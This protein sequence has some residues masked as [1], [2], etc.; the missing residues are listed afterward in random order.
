MGIKIKQH[1]LDLNKKTYVVTI[2]DNDEVLI[3]KKNI[4]CKT[5]LNANGDVI[6]DAAESL[7]RIKNIVA[8]RRAEE[9]TANV[10][11]DLG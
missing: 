2:E 9:Y 4:G 5:A 11:I 6:F 10:N 3:D 8:A 7:Q 1:T